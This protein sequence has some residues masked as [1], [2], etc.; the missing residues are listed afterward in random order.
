MENPRTEN[1]RTEPIVHFTENPRSEI[2]QFREDSR[3]ELVQYC[4]RRNT[5]QYMWDFLSELI[6]QY[7]EQSKLEIE[8]YIILYM[9][10]STLKV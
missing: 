9:E 6:V 7:T 4:I 5:V 3:S 1:S 2:V 10:D 8:Q